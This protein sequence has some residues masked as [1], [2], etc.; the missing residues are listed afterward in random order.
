[1]VDYKIIIYKIAGFLVEMKCYICSGKGNLKHLDR[2]VCPKCLVRNVEK[3]VKKHL[4]RKLFK[5]GDSVLVVGEVEECLLKAAVKN[6]PLN[7]TVGRQHLKGKFDKIVV[8][9][10][11]DEVDEEFLSQV[12]E[13]KIMVKEGKFFNILEPLSEEEVILYTQIKEVKFDR[14]RL[15][16]E[17]E[18]FLNGLRQFKEIKYN[19]Y[20]NIKELR[21]ILLKN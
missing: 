1:M 11:M 16:N 10:T 4:G 19:V 8:G 6:L 20:K 7:I 15:K 5:K 18:R 21:T 14:E 13:G 9:R 2:D 17:G 12:F 3:R